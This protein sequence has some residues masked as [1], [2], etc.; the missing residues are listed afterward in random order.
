[1]NETWDNYEILWGMDTTVNNVTASFIWGIE[2]VIALEEL[3]KKVG[4]SRGGLRT[5]QDLWN[6]WDKLNEKNKKKIVSVILYLQTGEVIVDKKQIKQYNVTTNDIQFVL[7]QYEEW[8]KQKIQVE[9][10]IDEPTEV[11]VSII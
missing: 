3:R 5:K 11:E 7:N 1:M 6:A 8:E 10:F 9:A 4:G 2:V